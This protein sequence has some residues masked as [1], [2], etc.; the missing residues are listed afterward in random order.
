[1]KL[2]STVEWAI[3]CCTFLAGL[4]EGRCLT[5]SDLAEFHGIPRP[6][7]AKTL[8]ALSSNGI[9]DTVSGPR[10]GYRLG[11]SPKKISLLDIVL[12]IEG[13]DST[14]ECAEIRRQGPAAMK[15]ASTYKHPCLIATAMWKAEKVWRDEL[16]KVKLSHLVERVAVEVDSRQLKK[17]KSWIEQ[18]LHMKKIKSKS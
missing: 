18:K 13:G 3:H 14:F 6:Y 1:M 5:G 17:A 8:Q 11:K 15:T 2:S 10:G 12:S 4:P 9:L 7:L 16:D